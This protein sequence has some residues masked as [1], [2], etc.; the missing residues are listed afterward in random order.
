VD[1][2]NSQRRLFLDEP[3]DVRSP[4][5]ETR[6]HLGDSVGAIVA[7]RDVG[8]AGDTLV[9]EYERGHVRK[10]AHPA[11]ARCARRPEIVKAESNTAIR[12]RAKP[13]GA[14]PGTKLADFVGEGLMNDA[15]R[16][17]R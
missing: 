9:A 10:A 4:C 7:R 14:C 16:R 3:F 2:Y 6:G 5:V 17:D 8:H 15:E 11:H 12:W 1:R 13:T